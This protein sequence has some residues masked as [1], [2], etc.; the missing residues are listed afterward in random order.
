M[1]KIG[2]DNNAYLAKQSE[3]MVCANLVLRGIDV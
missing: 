2:F 3:M 1:K